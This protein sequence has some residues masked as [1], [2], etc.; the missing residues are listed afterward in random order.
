MVGLCHLNILIYSAN[1]RAIS[2][3]P[4]FFSCLWLLGA[5]GANTEI[6]KFPEWSCDVQLSIISKLYT[7]TLFF[8]LPVPY[9]LYDHQ[10]QK[11][12]KSAS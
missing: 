12:K 5:T 7:I 4:F 3:L 1:I 11:S 6:I 2:T 10:D 8:P 9:A